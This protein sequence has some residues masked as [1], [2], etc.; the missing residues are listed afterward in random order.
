[1]NQRLHGVHTIILGRT[2]EQLTW[3]IIACVLQGTSEKRS[4]GSDKS[5]YLDPAYLDHAYLDH[6][7]ALGKR[8]EPK[9][10]RSSFVCTAG[11]NLKYYLEN[12]PENY[13]LKNRSVFKIYLDVLGGI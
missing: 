4:G 10:T 6:A 12:K 9:V 2:L 3:K 13:F 1:M 7:R 8:R 11:K 5:A